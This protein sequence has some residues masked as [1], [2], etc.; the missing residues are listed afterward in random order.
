[1]T[2]TFM[3]YDRYSQTYPD[4]GESGEAYDAEAFD[5]TQ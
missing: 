1:M 2:G 3:S 4:T 5:C